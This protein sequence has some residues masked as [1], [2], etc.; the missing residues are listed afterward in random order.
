MTTTTAPTTPPPP[1]TRWFDPKT[2]LPTKEF[3]QYIASLHAAV[4]TLCGKI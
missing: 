1:I 2:G 4:V 3:A